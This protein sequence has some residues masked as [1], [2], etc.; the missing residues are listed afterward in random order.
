M[1][2][3][4]NFNLTKILSEITL[5]QEKRREEKEEEFSCPLLMTQL[6]CKYVVE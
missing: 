1:L 2:P 4:K 5:R 6:A 3:E